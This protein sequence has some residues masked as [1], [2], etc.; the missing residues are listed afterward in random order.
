[1]TARSDVRSVTSPLWPPSAVRLSFNFS[2][3]WGHS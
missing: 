3:A 1:M 2:Y